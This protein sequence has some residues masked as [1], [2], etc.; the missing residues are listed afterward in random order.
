MGIVKHWYGKMVFTKSRDG[1]KFD[2]LT[3]INSVT[4]DLAE[5]EQFCRNSFNT[6]MGI[7]PYKLFRVDYNYIEKEKGFVQKWKPVIDEV[8]DVVK[9][10]LDPENLSSQLQIFNEYVSSKTGGGFV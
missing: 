9:R 1:Y 4:S 3:G 2:D 7:L 10:C 6:N 5:F 8:I